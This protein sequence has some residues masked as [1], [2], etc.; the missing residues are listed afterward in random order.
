MT[1]KPGVSERSGCCATRCASSPGSRGP[2]A[3]G[4]RRRP[5]ARTRGT[6]RCAPRRASYRERV[7]IER[8]S[9][10]GHDRESDMTTATTATAYEAVIGLE[11][12]CELATATK[13]FCG[14]PNEFG[15]R[16]EHEHLPGVPRAAGLAAGAE[17]AARSSSRCA[18]RR[19]SASTS[20]SARS[21]LGRTT[22]IPTCR[23]TTRSASTRTRSSPTARSRST[24]RRS[25]SSARTSRRTPAR[26]STSVVA[27]ASTRPTTRSSTTTAPASRSWRS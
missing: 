23:R 17:R 5:R 16:A 10:L 22:S 21:S 13:L 7:R 15:V 24:A 25:G 2:A 6:G 26:P 4:T 18:S 9:S 20:R 1:S 11:V 14:C 19:R 3:A 27:A 8:A 12:H